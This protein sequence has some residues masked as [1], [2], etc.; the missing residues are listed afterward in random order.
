MMKKMNLGNYKIAVIFIVHVLFIAIKNVIEPYLGIETATPKDK[1]ELLDNLIDFF[2]LAVIFAPLLEEVIF[3]YPLKKC[4]YVYIA[5]VLGCLVS[6]TFNNRF[7]TYIFIAMNIISFI[8]FFFFKK[9]ILPLSV[10]LI[11]TVL[12]S[13]IH[14]ENYNINDLGVLP[15][16]SL[17]YQFFPQLVLGLILTYIRIKTRFLYALAYHSAY[18]FVLFIIIVIGLKYFNYS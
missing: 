15:W 6:F 2:V 16:G 14:V 4:K 1:E 5:L 11:Y 8:L 13:L 9:E 7:F 18:N 17:I 3:R 12:F 10:L